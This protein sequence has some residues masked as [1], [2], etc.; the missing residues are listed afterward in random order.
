M[1]DTGHAVLLGLLLFVIL[2]ANQTTVYAIPAF[3]RREGMSCQMCHFRPPELNEDG[4]AYLRRG[5]REEPP[6]AQ[7]AMDMPANQMPMGGTPTKAPVAATP[8]P[9]GEPLPFQWADYLS[10]IGH[11]MYTLQQ[12]QRPQ[13]DAG[14]IDVWVAGPL[15]RHWSG[16]ANP[17]FNIEDGGSSVDQAYGQAITRWNSRFGSARFGQLLPFAILLNQGGPSMPLSTPLILSTPA[18]TG[19]VWSPT[20]LVRGVEVGAIN[21]PRW[22]A[23]LGVGQ[24]HLEGAPDLERHTDLYASAEYLID[25][26]GN[27]ITAY[28]YWG[29]ASFF[30]GNTQENF[31][32]LGVFGN[33]FL[34]KT[35][36][37]AGYLQGADQLG[38][39]Q[40][41]E[42]HGAFLQAEQLLS[43][44]WAAYVRYDHLNRDLSAGGGQTMQ[45][46]TLG[47]SWWAQT[48]VRLT[49]EVQVL[50]V[51]GER[52][53]RVFT[54]EFMWAF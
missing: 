9:L 47:V 10:V 32:R 38:T 2:I 46:P 40:T 13:F 24:P 52:Q 11:H 29:T 6:G 50:Q 45:G 23:Y 21:L 34:P 27:S 25:P 12:G 22:N 51:T 30:P 31:H 1:R 8:R 44:R 16:L 41:L 7:S 4:R 48:Q 35:K 5:L 17:S 43:D 18:D 33:I 28:G 3:A 37:V 20:T 54:T 53:N 14:I 19:T 36:I 39:G 26:R 49:S 15:D 42:D